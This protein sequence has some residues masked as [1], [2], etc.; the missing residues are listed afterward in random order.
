[1]VRQPVHSSRNRR[2]WYGVQAGTLRAVALLVLVSVLSPGSFYGAALRTSEAIAAPTHSTTIA[3]TSDETRLVVV[4][5]ESLS[6]K[7]SA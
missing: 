6:E 3:L 7:W 5:R 4:N 1:M 2:H